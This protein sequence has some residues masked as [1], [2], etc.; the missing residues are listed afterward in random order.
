MK[1]FY[2]PLKVKIEGDR[3]ITSIGNWSCGGFKL[4]DGWTYRLKVRYDT[5]ID[6]GQETVDVLLFRKTIT[7]WR[8]LMIERG[9]NPFKGY[10]AL[11]GG[12]VDEGETPLEAA[13]RELCEET[14]VKIDSSKFKQ[15]T[16][17][18]KEWRDPR[19][20]WAISTSFL[21]IID[22]KI[23]PKAGDDARKVAWIDIDESGVY[24]NGNPIEL[25]F[26]HFEIIKTTLMGLK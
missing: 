25:A 4:R 7:G 8:C 21:T 20:K 17:N 12:F 6:I 19:Q 10:W 13:I 26:D 14:G 18:D 15:I 23:T 24:F 2:P 3:C 11:P 22:S 1:D 16:V 5:I 9:Q